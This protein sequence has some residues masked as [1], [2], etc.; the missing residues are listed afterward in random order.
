MAIPSRNFVPSLPQAYR[1]LPVELA[2]LLVGPRDGMMQRT[3][4]CK[5][6]HKAFEIVVEY[7]RKAG[8]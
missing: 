5:R 2:R 7:K 8:R 1:R 4:L 6:C 3:I